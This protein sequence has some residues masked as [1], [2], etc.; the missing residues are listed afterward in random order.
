MKN[1]KNVLVVGNQGYLG[2]KITDYLQKCGHRCTGA[3][4]GFF[5]HGVLYHP[6][7]INILN[8]EARTITERDLEGHDIVLL[9]AGISNDPF[10]NLD[11][12]AIYDPT[13]LY[14]VKIA[15]MCKKL[16]IRYIF[17]SSCSIYGDTNSP[18]LLDENGPTHPLTPYSLNKLQIEQELAILADKSFSPIALR[19]G[20]VF[21]ASP[22]IRFDLVVNMLCAMAITQKKVIL[23]SNGQ[24]WRPH[25]YIDDV[26]AAVQCCIEWDYNEG[27][28]MVLNVGHD[29]NNWRIIDIARFIQSQVKDCQLSFLQSE[30]KNNDDNLFADR[31]VKN[32][33]D[34]RN[35]KVSFTRIHS[36]LPNF[37]I[38]WDVERGI[39]KLLEDLEY[40]QLDEIKF[41]QRDFYRLQHMEYLYKTKQIDDNLFYKNR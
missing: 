13:R 31:K 32:G 16:G 15:Q 27:K 28:L 23:N 20:T 22:R 7:K 26:C 4:I 24:V 34:K 30:G 5:Q 14:A 9:L 10:G 19:L 8:K 1:A 12:E 36:T 38:E 21:G 39:K 35:Y 17:P 18:K 2:S 29:D 37:K 11:S 3:D 40:W 41:R 33:I 25:L 6:S